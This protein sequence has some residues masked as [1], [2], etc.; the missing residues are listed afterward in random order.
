VDPARDCLEA[1]KAAV[2]P[3]SPGTVDLHRMLLVV[4]EALL[5]ARAESER[6]W[7]RAANAD[8]ECRRL[9]LLNATLTDTILPRRVRDAEAAERARWEPKTKAMEKLLRQFCDECDLDGHQGH[10]V[11]LARALLT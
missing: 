11:R 7:Q 6:E 9:L 4:E 10:N 5:D 2:P 1:L 8:E 3:A